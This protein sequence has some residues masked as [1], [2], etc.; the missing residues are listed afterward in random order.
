[1]NIAVRSLENRVLVLMFRQASNTTCVIS[2][3]L[4]FSLFF[5]FFSLSSSAAAAIAALSYTLAAVFSYFFLLQS[6][7]SI[8]FLSL[9]SWQVELLSDWSTSLSF[10]VLTILTEG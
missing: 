1:M 9:I 8:A 7:V 2:K 3:E 6:C 4:L 10:C 5:L